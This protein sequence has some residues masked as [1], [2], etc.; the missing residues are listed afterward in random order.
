[1][2]LVQNKTKTAQFFQVLT[3]PGPHRLYVAAVSSNLHLQIV[4]VTLELTSV[5]SLARTSIS[6]VA[7]HSSNKNYPHRPPGAPA[8]KP[9]MQHDTRCHQA[10]GTNQWSSP[11]IL[12]FCRFDLILVNGSE[13]EF[14][15]RFI[16]LLQVCWSRRTTKTGYN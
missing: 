13:T 4:A 11:L 9:M 6:N 1:M 8:N 15:L 16:H 10:C 12:L 14:L 3:L 7:L 5:Y 2:T